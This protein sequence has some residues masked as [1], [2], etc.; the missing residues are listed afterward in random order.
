MGRRMC[1]SPRRARLGGFSHQEQGAP[2]TSGQEC[3]EKLEACLVQTLTSQLG[4]L[5]SRRAGTCLGTR[6]HSAME[7]KLSPKPPSGMAGYVLP[8]PKGVPCP[9]TFLW[10]TLIPPPRLPVDPQAPYQRRWLCSFSA[11]R[12]QQA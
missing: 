1:L 2:W 9:P 3:I 5:R 11:W 4:R 10:A 12:N 6:S 8:L 7:L